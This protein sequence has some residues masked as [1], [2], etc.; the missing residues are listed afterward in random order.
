M[1]GLPRFWKL[2]GRENVFYAVGFSGNGVGPCHL[3]GRILAALA[4]EKH[5]EWTECGLV[6]PATRD[7]PPEPF[8][9][10][11]SKMIRHALLAK[12][13]ADDEGREPSF[14][15]KLGLRFAPAGVSPIKSSSGD[16]DQ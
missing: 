14:A 16:D 13:K 3:G 9:M 7:F 5:D 6:R 4:L 15:A 2:D 10:I 1:A 8:R 12:D 11:G